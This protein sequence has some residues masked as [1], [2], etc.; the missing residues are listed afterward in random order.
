MCCDDRKTHSETTT[1]H[2]YKTFGGVRGVF[3]CG[4]QKIDRS[5]AAF[6]DCVCVKLVE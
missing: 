6:L 2:V 5:Q 4:A 3:E 1:F